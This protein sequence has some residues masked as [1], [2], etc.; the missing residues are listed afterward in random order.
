VQKDLSFSSWEVL[1]LQKN[2]FFDFQPDLESFFMTYKNDFFDFFFI[3]SLFVLTYSLFFLNKMTFIFNKNGKLIFLI[4]GLSF[5]MYFFGGDGFVNDFTG[6]IVS[7]ICI[8]FLFITYN[9]F[10]FL[11]RRKISKNKL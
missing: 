6:L 1:S 4:I 7:F 10:F 2:L 9:F 3:M 8:E 5:Y 11:K